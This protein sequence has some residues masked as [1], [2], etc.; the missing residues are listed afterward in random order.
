MSTKPND[1]QHINARILRT[2]GALERTLNRHIH[3]LMA[4]DCEDAEAAEAIRFAVQAAETALE[5]AGET[6]RAIRGG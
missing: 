1:V 5:K 6:R 4:L 3:D 2:L